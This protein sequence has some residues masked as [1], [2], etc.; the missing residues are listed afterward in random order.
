MRESD[1]VKAAVATEI[2]GIIEERR[3]TQ[4]QAADLLRTDQ[5]KVS[6]I[7][8]GRLDGFS[9]E[10]LVNFLSDLG[11]SVEVSFSRERTNVDNN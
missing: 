8:T 4:R 1:R 6:R 5:P 2:A 3:L 7:V 9:V 10:R 11:G